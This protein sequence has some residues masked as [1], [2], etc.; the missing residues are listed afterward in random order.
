[1]EMQK[2]LEAVK[3]AR[4]AKRNF[5]QSFDLAINLK[6]IDLKKPEN[7]IKVEIPLPHGLGKIS[8]IAIIADS[9]VPLVKKIEGDNVI[10]IRKDELDGYGKNKRALKKLASECRTF[11]A[12]VPLM[13][14]V[15]K[16]LGQVLAPRD[17]MPKPLP[18]NIPDLKPIIL[19]ASNIIKV[20]VKNSNVIHCGV[21]SEDFDDNKIAENINA[22]LNAVESAL[23]KGREQMK[24]I[25]VKL[26]MG[27]VVKVAI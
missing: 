15:G 25:C 6:H 4:N 20:S 1:M 12:E 27:K 2:I 23:P 7:K 5:K 17:K 16:N 8:K 22:I 13:P 14:M 10:L 24:S 21:G 19:K 18:A 11:F 26:T 9:L 3:S